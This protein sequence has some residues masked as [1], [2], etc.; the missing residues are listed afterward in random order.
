[1]GKVARVQA[2]SWRRNVSGDLV[3][4][5]G[6]FLAPRPEGM[7]AGQQRVQRPLG[8]PGQCVG[9]VSDVRFSSEHNEMFNS[10]GTL[11]PP[12]GWGW[13]HRRWEGSIL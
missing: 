13:S 9:A 2:E 3:G 12:L 4:E 1:M 5:A 7:A 10:G 6:D 8:S 11:E